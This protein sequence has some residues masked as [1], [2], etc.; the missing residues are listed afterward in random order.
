MIQITDVQHSLLVPLLEEHT[1]CLSSHKA[2][3]DDPAEADDI[4]G[5]IYVARALIRA[6]S[7]YSTTYSGTAACVAAL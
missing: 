5:D 6:I 1:D 3:L 2:P 4:E 7:E